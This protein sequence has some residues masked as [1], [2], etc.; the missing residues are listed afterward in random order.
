VA[1]DPTGGVGGAPPKAVMERDAVLYA[2]ST[3][4]QTCAAL[5]AFV[6]ALALYK[7]QSLGAEQARNDHNIRGILAGPVL[8]QNQVPILPLSRVIEVA[9]AN[10]TVSPG[11]TSTVSESLKEAVAEWDG[12]PARRRSATKGLFVFEAWNLLLIGESLVGFNYVPLLQSSPCSFWGLWT[13]AI[14]TV[15][16]TGYGVYAWTR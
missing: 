2:L 4:A 11:L 13:A 8:S 1:R 6:S 10:S 14:G 5:A 7:L 15:A 9:R 16:V 12:F 3:L